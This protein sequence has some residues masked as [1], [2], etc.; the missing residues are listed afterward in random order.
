MFK[1]PLRLQKHFTGV[2]IQN[3]IDNNRIPA[4]QKIPLFNRHINSLEGLQNIPDIKNVQR[5]RQ[6]VSAIAPNAVIIFY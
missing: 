5:I 4:G 1:I 2:S 6:E 3:L